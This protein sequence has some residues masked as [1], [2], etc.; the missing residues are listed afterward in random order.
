MS[1][2]LHLHN[3]QTIQ[4]VSLKT[5]QRYIEEKRLLNASHFGFHSCNG[6]KLQ[7]MTYTEHITSNFNNKMSTAALFLDI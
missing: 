7:C 2:Q 4:E 5:I 6:M 1:I 3:R